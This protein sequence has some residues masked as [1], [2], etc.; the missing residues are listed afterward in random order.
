MKRSITGCNFLPTLHPDYSIGL[1][2]V[3]PMSDVSGA[4]TYTG[5]I[6]GVAMCHIIFTYIITLDTP[7][8]DLGYENWTSVAVSG[9]LIK[10]L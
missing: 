7:M 9:T 2:C 3:F 6:T 8:T 4:K 1:Q 5:R 10:P